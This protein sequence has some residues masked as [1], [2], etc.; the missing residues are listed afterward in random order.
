MGVSGVTAHFVWSRL[1]CGLMS[2]QMMIERDR[3]SKCA[4]LCVIYSG[5]GEAA[6]RHGGAVSK[7]NF[8]LS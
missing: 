7:T 1:E 2:P 6:C 5:D 4:V 3:G 8:L